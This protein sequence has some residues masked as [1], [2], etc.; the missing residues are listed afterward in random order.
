M[1]AWDA[2]QAMNTFYYHIYSLSYNHIIHIYIY[3]Y[4]I[5]IYIYI[6]IHIFTFLADLSNLLG[7]HRGLSTPLWF[8]GDSQGVANWVRKQV[9]YLDE[10]VV[11][12]GDLLELFHVSMSRS[13][14]GLVMFYWVPS[15]ELTF[16]H[17]K[18]PFLMGQS[19]IS[20]A[21]FHCYG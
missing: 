20:M 1:Q 13:F 2:L 5:N 7:L 21:I 10:D 16:C 4:I 17:G 14:G 11:V 12:K 9:V 3:I 8:L 19:T 15:G 6:Y 18:S